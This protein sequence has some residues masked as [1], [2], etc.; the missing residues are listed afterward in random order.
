MV[1]WIYIIIALAFGYQIGWIITDIYWRKKI[2][3]ERNKK[4]VEKL[5]PTRLKR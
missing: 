3:L 4:C 5:L 2:K 1:H